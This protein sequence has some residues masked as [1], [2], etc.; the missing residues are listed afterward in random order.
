MPSSTTDLDVDLLN[1]KVHA[2]CAALTT[3]LGKVSSR[4]VE[5]MLRGLLIGGS[6][7]LTEIARASGE[8]IPLHATHKRLSRNLGDRRMGTTVAANLLKAGAQTIHDDTLLVIDV[9]E[10]VKPYAEKME[11]LRKTEGDHPAA[12]PARR[13]PADDGQPQE[14]HDGHRGYGVCEI[15]GW[16]LDG[17]PMP[18]FADLAREMASEA[19]GDEAISAWNN[20]VVTPLA[21]TLFSPNAPEFRTETDET[22]DLVRRV[23]DACDGRG[24][25]AIDIVGLRRGQRLLSRHSPELLARQH[26][27]PETLAATTK[28]RFAARVPSDYPL[29]HNRSHTTALEVSQ[30]CRTPYGVT[31]YKHGENKDFGNFVHF[32]SAPVRLPSCP[33]KPLWLVIVKGF[34][35]ELTAQPSVWDPYLVLTTEPMR[36]NRKVLW[37]LAWSFLSY[38]DAI[39]TNQAIKDQFDFDDVRVLSYD[40]LR[41]IGI[42]VLA[43]SFV[44]AQWPGIALQKSLFR[45]RQAASPLQFRGGS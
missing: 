45:T 3:G 36:R 13:S 25:F 9:F 8:S 6:V 33:D 5:D 30:G 38:W 27:L 29:L 17:G 4:F 32:G 2:I 7:R 39:G 19:N 11:Y 43:A 23:D 22:L 10:V 1:T 34:A 15:F 16:D 12:A 41:N 37:D 35:G 26:K 24:V 40:R 20:L 18:Q 28:C 14:A 21:Q 31:L 42:L 44:E